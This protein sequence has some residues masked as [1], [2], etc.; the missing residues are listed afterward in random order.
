MKGFD[1]NVLL[2][3]SLLLLLLLNLRVPEYKENFM[4]S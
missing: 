2:L 1:R 3:L 4:T